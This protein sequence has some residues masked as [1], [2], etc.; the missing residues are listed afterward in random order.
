[1]FHS[2]IG[3]YDPKG[4]FVTAYVEE[5][6]KEDLKTLLN[7]FDTIEKAK[8]LVSYAYI[9]NIPTDIS[10]IE[11]I[12]PDNLLPENRLKV[13]KF[14]TEERMLL[15]CH[16]SDANFIFIYSPSNGWFFGVVKPTDTKIHF[17]KLSKYVSKYCK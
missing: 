9:K 7:T 16:W 10:N 2:I 14:S 17:I 3:Y 12:N 11:K 5:Y 15:R 4:I 6:K 13:Q 8:K 1:M